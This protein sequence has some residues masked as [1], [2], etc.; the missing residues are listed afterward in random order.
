MVTKQ[1]PKQSDSD[2]FD[3]WDAYVYAHQHRVNQILALLATACMAGLWWVGSQM[4]LPDLIRF[5]PPVISGERIN[6]K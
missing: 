6:E 5:F 2:L 3:R 1:P 4:S